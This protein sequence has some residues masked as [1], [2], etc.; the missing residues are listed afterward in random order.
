M[1]LK[2]TNVHVELRLRLLV[3]QDKNDLKDVLKHAALMVGEL[4]TSSLT[5]K[6]YY[7]LYMYVFDNL[8]TLESYFMQLAR[9]GTECRDIYNAVQQAA[10]ILPRMY[11]MVTAGSVYVRSGQASAHDVLG[12]LIE[13]VKGVQH[14]QRGLFVRYY[15][16]QRMKDKLPDHPP[17]A[18]TATG[19]GAA[20][21]VSAAP[22][23][24][25]G[26]GKGSKVAIDFLVANLV[27][28]NRLWVRMQ[29]PTTGVVRN[30][31]RRERERQEL[32]I[33]VGANLTRLSQL[34]GLDVHMYTTSVLPKVSAEIISCRDKIAQAY[35]VEGLLQVFP[36][37]YHIATLGTLLGL[38]PQLVPDHATLKTVALS[39]LSRIQQAASIATDGSSTSVLSP[40]LLS[41][42]TSFVIASKSVLGLP[43]PP[44]VRASSSVLP[45]D[46]DVF[47]TILQYISQLALDAN[48]PFRPSGSSSSS[49]S[50]PG[51]APERRDSDDGDGGGG[52]GGSGGH[53]NG[54]AAANGTAHHQHTPVKA[55]S[56]ARLAALRDAVD[57]A[58]AVQPLSSLLEIFQGLLSFT[59]SIYPGHMPY[60]DAVLGASATS[61]RD[62]LGLA[63]PQDPATVTAA[64]IGEVMDSAAASISDEAKAKLDAVAPPQQQRETATAGVPSS[65]TA[66]AP[67]VPGGSSGGSGSSS[68][69]QQPVSG[70][71][72]ET[73][74]T[75]V[76]ALLS[77]AQRSLGLEVLDLTH[78]AGLM[79]PLGY[80]YRRDVAAGLLASILETAAA[81]EVAVASLASAP[82]TPAASSEAP[83]ASAVVAAA[84]TSSALLEG[85]GGNGLALV[86]ITDT[87]TARRLLAA[88]QPL[89]RD[90]ADD[91]DVQ[92]G[93]AAPSEKERFTREQTNMAKL[94]HLMGPAH[95]HDD[96]AATRLVNEAGRWFEVLTVARDFLSWGGPSRVTWTY[97]ALLNE[98]LA[99]AKVAPEARVGAVT[100]K[101][102]YTFIHELAST[103]AIAG[104]TE[105][106]IQLY[107]QA[108]DG[109]DDT[110]FGLEFY[111]QGERC[112]TRRLTTGGD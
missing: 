17:A 49:S 69:Q 95:G 28:M 11:L 46:V 65:M 20:A 85:G 107:L 92:H 6:V 102:V 18:A 3:L 19:A 72:D 52:G 54:A 39:L 38:L 30:R 56:G 61:L 82:S 89:I 36:L 87:D 103:V 44:V 31:K 22:A 77:S 94:V 70:G 106:A 14:A 68:Q 59:L 74:S 67:R 23:A 40:K 90:D 55:K 81:A 108:A 26:D 8:G 75:L 1:T 25:E 13:C 80:R 83:S 62:L 88:L 104:H 58:V 50:A 98:A 7:E 97:P 16:V 4:R 63:Q 35:L 47:G 48:G 33:L 9:G 66:A 60:V 41:P 37:E 10:H 100:R 96:N 79:A 112:W 101:K 5:P 29:A 76:V 73:C 53:S 99:L 24:S 2:S 34:D 42:T 71:L 21:A 109:C 84:I 78:Y 27:E 111:S 105:Q 12:D 64:P 51:N 15:L 57:V 110:G 43:A 45:P 86:R 93:A 91:G 32:R